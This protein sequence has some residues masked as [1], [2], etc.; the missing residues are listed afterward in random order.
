MSLKSR[1]VTV[2]VRLYPA[3]W[4]REYGSE[5]G[6]MLLAR[7]LAV[8]EIADV[9]WN[10]IRQR[11]RSLEPTTALGVAVMLVVV[12]TFASGL[13]VLAPSHMTFPAVSIPPL[14]SAPYALFLVVCGCAIHLRTGASPSRAGVAAMK[15]SFIGGLPILVAGLLLLA[16]IARPDSPSH[17]PGGW[18]LLAAPIARLGE[19]WLWGM[20]GGKLGR[21]IAARSS[22]QVWKRS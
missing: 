17:S 2:L 9:V 15:I 21:T 6:D 19:S 3:P 5:L 14:R 20:V 16:G 8:R 18:H 1:L 4:R 22:F 12:A 7:P 11:L 10:G 13:P